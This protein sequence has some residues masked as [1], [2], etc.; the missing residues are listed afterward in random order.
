MVLAVII[1]CAQ[2]IPGIPFFHPLLIW[3]IL[4]F[5]VVNLAL[6]YLLNLLKSQLE[7][8]DHMIFLAGTTFRLLIGLFCIL[9]F[10]VLKVESLKLFAVNFVIVY[11]LYLG[12]EITTL[13][14]NLRRNSS[15][16]YSR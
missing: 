2:Q 7:V 10:Y 5:W 12:F 9:I 3:M 14:R 1:L 11:L 6:H 15:Q 16:D 8:A 4:G 13:L